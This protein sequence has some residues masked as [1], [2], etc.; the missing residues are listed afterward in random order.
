[1]RYLVLTSFL[2]CFSSAQAANLRVT[3]VSADVN[4]IDEPAL[5]ITLSTEPLDFQATKDRYKSDGIVVELV[6]LG[7]DGKPATYAMLPGFND[8]S[9]QFQVADPTAELAK[10]VAREDA[11]IYLIASA[12]ITVT[13]ANQSNASLA[14]DDLKMLTSSLSLSQDAVDAII[15]VAQ[16]RQR[17]YEDRIDFAREVDEDDSTRVDYAVSFELSQRVGRTPLAVETRGRLSTNAES[18]MN[19]V[20]VSLVGRTGIGTKSIAG[21]DVFYSGFVDAGVVALQSFDVTAA[22]VSVGVDLLLPNFIDL[23]SGANRLRLK[24]VVGASVGFKQLSEEIDVYGDENGF[25]EAR[26]ELAYTIPILEAYVLHVRSHAVFNDNV[27]GDDEWFHLTSASLSYALPGNNI[28]ILAKWELG[29][30]EFVSEYDSEVLLGL[31]AD[32]LPM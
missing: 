27:E 3:S 32:F 14:R 18:P 19:Q 23:T 30:N 5:W 1:M 29:R 24:P 4:T 8:G 6:D 13:L 7:D 31:L 25:L 2:V 26:F 16:G 22:T 10:R 15:D 28:S 21:A 20:A 9:I 11:A 12:D 17:L